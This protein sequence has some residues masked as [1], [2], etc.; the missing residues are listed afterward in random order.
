M[1]FCMYTAPIRPNC[2]SISGRH[3][4]FAP[5]SQSMKKP[6]DFGISGAKAT[7]LIPLMRLTIS[8]APTTS[9][10]L[11]PAEAKASPR[12]S[13]SARRPT[14]IELSFFVRMI[15]VASSSMVITSGQPMISKS[16]IST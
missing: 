11:F 2:A 14:A 15:S 10:P 6:S 4:L 3:S 1:T 16:E 12:P 7:R 5:P 9:A 8:V 13:A